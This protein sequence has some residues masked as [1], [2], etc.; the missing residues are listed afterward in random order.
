MPT[1]SAASFCKRLCLVRLY[2]IRQQKHD[3]PL[4]QL[5]WEKEALAHLRDSEEKF[6]IEVET[7]ISKLMTKSASLESIRIHETSVEI[8]VSLGFFASIY[9]AVAGYQDYSEAIELLTSQL[10]TLVRKFLPPDV[11]LDTSTMYGS[12]WS[13]LPV[14]SVAGVGVTTIPARYLIIANAVLV[15]VLIYFL[16]SRY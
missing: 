13:L 3:V 1:V 8:I 5:M 16:F 4:E 12:R 11:S 9:T 14:P 7:L 6:E 10:R 15:G 2:V